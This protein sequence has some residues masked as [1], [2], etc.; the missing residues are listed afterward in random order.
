MNFNCQVIDL[1]YDSTDTL[2]NRCSLVDCIKGNRL[3]TA[4]GIRCSIKLGIVNPHAV[5]HGG[6]IFDVVKGD[7]ATLNHV[8]KPVQAHHFVFVID[9]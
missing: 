1:L 7:V 6:A 8:A 9:H 3:G 5:S 4:C 2:S